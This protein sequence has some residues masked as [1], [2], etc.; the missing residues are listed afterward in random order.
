MAEGSRIRSFAASSDLSRAIICKW[1][2]TVV[3]VDLQASRAC[4]LLGATPASGEWARVRLAAVTALLA[5]PEEL[6]STCISLPRACWP[7]FY[8]AACVPASLP[9]CCCR[10]G[11][12]CARCRNGASATAPLA[13]PLVRTPARPLARLPASLPAWLPCLPAS[14]RACLLPL[15]ACTSPVHTPVPP[16]LAH[17]PFTLPSSASPA[18]AVNH[19][20]LTQ[21]GRTAVTLSKDGTARVWDAATGACLHVLA[22]ERAGRR[23]MPACLLHHYP[24]PRRA[25]MPAT[26]STPAS[27]PLPSPHCAPHCAPARTPTPAASHPP[28]PPS[29]LCRPLGQRAWGRHLRRSPHAC[30]LFLRRLR[31]PV[32]AG[33]RPVHQLHPA[34][35][36]AAGGFM[37]VW[38]CRAME[39]YCPA[40]CAQLL[41][42][43][44]LLGGPDV[45]VSI[46]MPAHLST[47][48]PPP[49]TLLQHV[50]L[51]PDGWKVAVAMS[52]AAVCVFDV[53]DRQAGNPWEVSAAARLP[54]CAAVPCCV[55]LPACLPACLPRP[56]PGGCPPSGNLQLL[57]RATPT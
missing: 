36:H 2:S 15:A 23:A 50:A 37:C 48:L 24:I 16:L 22:G 57:A 31:A 54:A 19:V 38:L 12:A 52:S 20:L 14:L 30:H 42:P 28:A 32:G 47:Y 40:G 55:A 29:L 6:Q 21:D 41:G 43:A 5:R 26:T 51:S 53:E 34:A 27:L 3:V 35:R 46:C 25:P 56:A 4:F 44:L 1:D 33:Q 13:T 10:L 39:R 8:H 7:A 9:S 45:Y 17:A 49:S 18:A 11:S